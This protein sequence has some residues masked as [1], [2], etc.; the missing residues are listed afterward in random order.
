MSVQAAVG[1]GSS[2]KSVTLSLTDGGTDGVGI[3]GTDVEGQREDAVG[4]EVV[5]NRVILRAGT[6]EDAVVPLDGQPVLAEGGVE[7]GMAVA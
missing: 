7:R 1:I 3:D 6:G 5:R 4:S 2:L